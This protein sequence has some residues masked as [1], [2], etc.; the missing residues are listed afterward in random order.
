MKAHLIEAASAIVPSQQILINM[1]SRRVRQLTMGH[2]PLV[3]VLPT[4]LTS[5]IALMEIAQGKLTY[6]EV[7]A[8][9]EKTLVPFVDVAKKKAA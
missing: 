8:G 5:D 6:V 1:V 4:T 7:G 9:D 2:R 3:E